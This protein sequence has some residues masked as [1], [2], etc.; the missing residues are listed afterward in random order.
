MTLHAQQPA[1]DFLSRIGEIYVVVACIA[2]I[3]LG[4]V[5]YL[6]RLDSKLTKLEQHI[7][8]EQ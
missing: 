5:F 3:F 1:I 6:V 8:D 7:N 4:I 2:V